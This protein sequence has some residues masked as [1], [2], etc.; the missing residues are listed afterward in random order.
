MMS[1]RENCAIEDMAEYWM[2]EVLNRF[3]E[4]FNEQDK[5]HCLLFS[6]LYIG[7]SLNAIDSRL[8]HMETLMKGIYDKDEDGK[9]SWNSL[10][11]EIND[12]WRA[13]HAD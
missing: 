3:E 8:M 6:L 1:Q 12:R 11:R 5:V 7:H 9:H 2:D 13:R 10:M 4:P